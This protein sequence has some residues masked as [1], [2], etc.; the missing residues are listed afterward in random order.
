M[1]LHK[2]HHPC[3]ISTSLRTFGHMLLEGNTSNMW[4]TDVCVQIQTTHSQFKRKKCVFF[5]HYFH[6]SFIFQQSFYLRSASH[7][8]ESLHNNMICSACISWLLLISLTHSFHQCMSSLSVV[9]L[10]NNNPA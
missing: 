4:Q 8:V 6:I 10:A 9:S 1:T 3:H 2:S 5:C 7:A